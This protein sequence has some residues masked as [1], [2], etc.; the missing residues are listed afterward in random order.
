M[1]LTR[2]F[3]TVSLAV[4]TVA[5]PGC[6]VIARS[7]GD[8]STYSASSMGSGKRIGV[9]LASVSPALARQSGVNAATSALVTRVVSGLPAANA[10]FEQ[11]DIIKLVDGQPD[12][13]FR[14]V[15]K[16]ID[17]AQ[18]GQSIEFTVVRGGQ[19]LLIT[20]SAGAL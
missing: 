17:N 11:Y 1:R 3:L 8:A 18:P 20:V 6:I 15:R 16:A 9:E 4:S 14:A 13:S 12:G 10:G 7:Y 2:A 19:D 5:L